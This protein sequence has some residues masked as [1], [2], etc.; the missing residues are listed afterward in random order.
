M[1]LSDRQ[2]RAGHTNCR[3]LSSAQALPL[4][5]SLPAEGSFSPSPPG[6][7][8]RRDATPFHNI[9]IGFDVSPFVAPYNFFFS[10]L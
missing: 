5:G 10:S 7:F 1:G 3:L 8:K 2:D 4:P 6:E 9:L